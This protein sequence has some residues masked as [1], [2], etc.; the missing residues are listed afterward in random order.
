[1]STLLLKPKVKQ[2]KE[3]E[4]KNPLHCLVEAKNLEVPEVQEDQEKGVKK[5]VKKEVKEEKGVKK[6]LVEEEEDQ[7]EVKEGDLKEEARDT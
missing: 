5:E 4:A 6:N 7:R 2:Q 3:R 1:M